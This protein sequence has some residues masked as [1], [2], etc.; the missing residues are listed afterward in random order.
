[1][2]YNRF[3]MNHIWLQL[4][5]TGTHS[6]SY[7]RGNTDLSLS[8]VLVSKKGIETTYEYVLDLISTDIQVPDSLIDELISSQ[9]LLVFVLLLKPCINKSENTKRHG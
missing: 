7:K 8:N 9:S 6:F 5:L 2:S 4:F 3:N 1:M